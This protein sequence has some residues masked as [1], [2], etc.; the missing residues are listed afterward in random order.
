ME[1]TKIIQIKLSENLVQN[2]KVYDDTHYTA[3]IKIGQFTIIS[4]ISF[5]KHLV[6]MYLHVSVLKTSKRAYIVKHV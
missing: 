4:S 3:K 1:L 2:L 5:V 6:P